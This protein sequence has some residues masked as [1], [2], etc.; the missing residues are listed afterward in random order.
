MSMENRQGNDQQGS[1]KRLKQKKL[2]REAILY[3]GRDYIFVLPGRLRQ[4]PAS[5]D[6]LFQKA[7]E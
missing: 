5:M 3:I 6:N 1:N 4:Y 2:E 7:I